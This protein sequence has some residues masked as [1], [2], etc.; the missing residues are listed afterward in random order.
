MG[1]AAGDFRRLVES[2]IFGVTLDLTEQQRTERLLERY[3]LLSQHARDIVLFIR[4]DGRIIE[5]NDAAVSAYGYDRETLLTRT[6]F[7]LRDTATAPLILGQ[8]LQA[9]V[10]GITFETVHRRHDGS[11]FPV[12]V[13]SRGAEIAGE[14]LLLSVIRDISERKR[15]DEELRRSEEQLRSAFRAARMVGW[16]YDPRADR[17]ARSENAA[18]VFGFLPGETAEEGWAMVHPDDRPGHQARV[19]EALAAGRSYESEFRLVRPDSGE[20][21][22]LEDHGCGVYDDRGNLVRVSGVVLDVTERKRAEADLRRSRERLAETLAQVEAL[23][24]AAPV[25]VAL[26]DRDLRYVRINDAL[27]KLNGL[28]APEHL[29]RTLREVLPAMADEYEPA[30]REVIETG[31]PRLNV[32]FEGEVP[33]RPGHRGCWL[34][35][36]YPVRAVDG[37]VLGVGIMTAEIT[38][39]VRAEEELRLSERRHRTLTDAVLQLMWAN[40]PAGQTTYFNRRWEEYTGQASDSLSGLVWV[41]LIPPED[42][43]GLRDVRHA[44]IAA[45]EPYEYEYRLRRHDG[46]ER[47]HIARVV[48]VKDADGRVEGWFGTATDI[49]DRKQA[50]DALRAA[51]DAAEAASRAKSQFLAVLS[52]ELRTPLN[53]ALISVSALLDD[54][55]TPPSIRP[56]LEV[57]RRNIAMEARLIDDL[58]DVTRIA[59]DKLRLDREVADAHDLVR[60]AVEVCREEIVAKGLR[61][62][63]DLAAVAH[64]VEADPARLQQ[65]AWN[66]VKNA[67]KFTPA[68]GMI[69]VRSRNAEEPDLKLIVEVC[70]TG[71]GIEPEA[72]PRIFDAFEQADATVTRQFGGLG[73]GLAI[74][75]SLAEAHG[76][77]L[78]AASA[79][80]GRGATFTLTLPTTFA[81][82]QA[83]GHPSAD[84]RGVRPTPALR[85]LLVED[86]LDSLRVLARLLGRRGHSVVTASSLGEA[87]QLGAA[88]AFDVVISDIGLPDGSGLDLMRTIRAQVRLGGIA[89]SGF[90]MEQDLRRSE[91]AGFTT[92]L[93]KPIDFARLEAVID[94]VAE[95]GR[96]G[97][98]PS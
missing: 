57:T 93:T 33:G 83:E 78:A 37:R 70:D 62:E 40:D 97:S 71:L 59:Q 60:R 17:M 38:E 80:H 2:D 94:Q 75:R 66:L 42:L 67:G 36:W 54:P 45:G 15:A 98:Q 22:W 3:R 35:N 1:R 73:L 44:G 20:T 25:A 47:W 21:I 32:L 23:V 9:D 91:E 92:H 81:R 31:L 52:H 18:E 5:A 28:S 12:E 88:E 16:N 74:S 30:L 82:R 87:V 61:L 48:P 39:Q 68:G 4:P 19:G 72:L 8:L 41:D 34:G 50:E 69:S 10:Q 53:P 86:N 13:S 14:R 51:R 79:G 58:L 96:V 77:S 6:I 26:L 7:E 63:I 43:P 95:S 65:I 56:A 11:T 29:G 64:H 55:A 49:H 90:G 89:L 46:Q 27:A 76:G 84:D 24:A 85:I